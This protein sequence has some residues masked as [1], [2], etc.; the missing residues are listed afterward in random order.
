MKRTY[1]EIKGMLFRDVD[2]KI[3]KHR[4]TKKYGYQTGVRLKNPVRFGLIR[5][6]TTG[7]LWMLEDFPWNGADV[8]KDTDSNTRASAIHDAL[9]RL[10]RYGHLDKKWIKIIN[11]IYE[12]VCKEDGMPA[13][14][15]NLHR[16]GLRVFWWKARI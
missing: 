4:L 11:D 6:M 15:Y 12:K 8:V 10:Y 2:E 1:H 14:R 5:L 9:C 16:F 7:K 3:F 13:W